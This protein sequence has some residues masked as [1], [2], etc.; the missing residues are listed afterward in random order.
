M[1]PFRSCLYAGAVVHKRLVPKRHGFAYRVF[2]LC[3]DVDEIDR[4]DRELRLFSRGRANLLSFYD[5]DC[6]EAGVRPIAEKTRRLLAEAGLECFG[7]RIELLTYPRILGYVFT[8]LS[9]FFCHD[10]GGALGAV[11]YEVTNTFGERRSYLIEAGGRAR[12]TLVQEC[13]KQLYVS[14]FT[15]ANGTYSFHVVAPSERI[16]IG[17]A[18]RDGDQ[19]VLKTHFRGERIAL[20]DASVARL[21]ARHPLMTL[22]VVGAIHYEALRL[23]LKG[24]PLVPRHVSP[25][26]AA[27]IVRSPSQELGHA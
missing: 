25:A 24:V 21:L 5:G 12:E 27:T 15:G 6:G 3:L 17:V 4:L 2:A 23:W 1:S 26:Y 13:R 22:K 19:P 11:I 10:A 16:V 8:P 20:T 18:F 7:A 14:P 9:V